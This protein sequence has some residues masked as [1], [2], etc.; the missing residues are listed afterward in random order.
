MNWFGAPWGVDCVQGQ[1]GPIVDVDLRSGTTVT[2]AYG[3]LIV[4]SSGKVTGY[5]AVGPEE[6]QDIVDTDAFNGSPTGSEVKYFFNTLEQAQ[7][8]GVS[9]HY[10]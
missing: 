10:S 2:T 9:P 3:G 6:F 5:R 1:N 7:S 8:F 4:N